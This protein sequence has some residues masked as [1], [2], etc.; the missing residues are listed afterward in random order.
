MTMKQDQFNELQRKN[1]DAAMRLAQMSI[2]NSQRIMQMQVDTAKSLFEKGVHN[3]KA[4]AEAK[5]PQ[6]MM[7]LRTQFAQETTEKMLSCARE[8]A[9]I[10]T[11]TQAEFGRMVSQQLTSGSKEIM[12]AFQKVLTGMPVSSHGAT[13]AF[14][15]AMQTAQSAFDQI[16]KASGDAFSTFTSMA[17]QAGAPKKGK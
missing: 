11:Q 14:Q 9:E 12:E 8:I 5:D 1:L 17:A 7:S 13:D 10:T 2:E 15:A 6:T 16:T 3:A 4:L